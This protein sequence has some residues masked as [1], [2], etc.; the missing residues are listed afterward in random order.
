MIS[1]LWQ[2]ILISIVGWFNEQQRLKLEFTLEQLEV[3][4]DLTG[5]KRL[6]LNDDHR[7]RLA[8][9][10]RKL[11]LSGLREL[12]T[13]VTPE[14]I[15]RWHR[16]LV[17]KKYDGSRNRRPGRPRI[18]DE[19]RAPIVRMATENEN[20]GYTRIVGELSKLQIKYLGLR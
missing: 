15:M 12:V 3:Y 2:L 8:V 9:K 11:G 4:K 17:A 20:W 18:I 13:M 14:T 1:N 7:C 5:D 6:R 16:E 10:D 19:I